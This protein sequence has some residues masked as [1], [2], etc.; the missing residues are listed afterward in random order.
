MKRTLSATRSGAKPSFVCAY[1]W[2]MELKFRIWMPV[3]PY[4]S[5]RGMVRKTSSG[6]PSV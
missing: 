2:K 1:S 6:I 4:N 3:A 5:S